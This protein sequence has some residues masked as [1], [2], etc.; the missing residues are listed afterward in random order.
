MPPS[1]L[2]GTRKPRDS[3]TKFARTKN[4]EK[5]NQIGARFSN[6]SCVFGGGGGGFS[7]IAANWRRQNVLELSSIRFVSLGAQH[8]KL[9]RVRIDSELTSVK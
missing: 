2:Q 8:A 7:E 5:L 4:C 6:S 9:R 3:L 1:P